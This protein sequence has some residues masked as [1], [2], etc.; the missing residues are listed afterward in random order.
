MS[1]EYQEGENLAPQDRPA[2]PPVL[3]KTTHLE[4]MSASWAA[5]WL[6]HPSHVRDMGAS[7][8]VRAR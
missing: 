5:L 1:Q 3:Q 4:A 8:R 7:M 6:T 2:L